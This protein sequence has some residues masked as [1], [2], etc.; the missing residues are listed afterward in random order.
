MDEIISHG[1]YAYFKSGF[2]LQIAITDDEVLLNVIEG[3]HEKASFNLDLNFKTNIWEI[4]KEH[5]DYAD[6]AQR[7]DGQTMGLIEKFLAQASTQ[8]FLKNL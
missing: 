4:D 8:D 7:V 3:A 2:Q 5:E 6:S 1:I